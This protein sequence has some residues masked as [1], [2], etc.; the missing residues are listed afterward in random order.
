V[1]GTFQFDLAVAGVSTFADQGDV[2]TTPS[3]DD[4]R[5]YDDLFTLVVT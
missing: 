5:R 1:G 2:N 4:A 3:A